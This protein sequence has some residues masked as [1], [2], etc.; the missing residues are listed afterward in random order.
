MATPSL[1]SIAARSLRFFLRS[2]LALVLGIAAATAVI[3]GALAVGDSV[4]GSL[5]NLVVQRLANIECLLQARVFFDPSVVTSLA[6]KQENSTIVPGIIFPS[7][8]VEKRQD[9]N[10]TRASRVQLI[11]LDAQ[12]WAK[13][14]MSEQR[15]TIDAD[16]VVLNQSLADELEVAVGDELSLRINQASGVSGDNPLGKKEGNNISV[17]RQKVVAILPDESV[18]G[19]SF[20]AGQAAPRNVFASLATI[21][22]LLECGS[23]VNAALV[24]RDSATQETM[25]GQAQ[26]DELNLSINP[27]LEDYGLQLTRHRRVFPDSQLDPSS[28]T[29]AEQSPAVVYDYL[30]LSSKELVIDDATSSAVYSAV[31][32]EQSTRLITYL[33]NA[34]AKIEPLQSDLGPD[35]KAILKPPPARPGN[36]PRLLPMGQ[37]RASSQLAQEPASLPLISREVPYSIVVGVDR[38]SPLQLEDYIQVPE[39]SLRRPFC[40]VNS[41]LAEQLDIKP[42]EW[43]QAD[44]FEPETV[45]GREVE[46]KNRFMVAGIVP[47]TEPSR[48]FDR[49]REAAFATTPT[50]FNDPSLT[51]SV[52]GITDQESISNWDLP[53]KLEKTIPP[54]DDLYWKNHRLTPKVFVPYAYA[55]SDEMFGSRFGHTTAIRFSNEKSKNEAAL[56]A[57][58][59][60]ALLTTRLSKGLVFQPIRDRQLAASSGT[61]PFDMLFL[62]LSFFV[63]VAA[64]MLV[65]LLFRLGIQQRSSELGILLAQGFTPA[66]VRRLLLLEFSGVAILGAIV[67]VL[68]GIGYARLMIAGL[69]TWWIGAIAT[70]FLNF[71]VT[72]QSILLGA[73]SGFIASTV[74]IYFGLR[75]LSGM[76]ALAVLQG[77]LSDES[78]SSKSASR[79][80]LAVAGFLAFGAIGLIV[81][82][83]GQAGMARA[84]SFFGS[85]MLL[86]AA[87]LIAIRQWIQV[88]ISAKQ[89]PRK[90]SLLHLAWKAVCKNPL[91]S[92]LSLSLLAVATFLITSMGVFQIS[93]SEK[94]YGGFNL[95]AE[96]SQPIFRDLGSSAVRTEALG[97]DARLLSG[98]TILPM[99]ARLG[100]DASC[101]NLFQ[102]AQPTILGVP[103]RLAEMHD[104]DSKTAEFEW[105]ASANAKNPWLPLARR[106]SGGRNDPIPVILDQNTAAWSLK[107]GA[108]LGAIVRIEL[109]DQVLFFQT[110]GLLSN[111]VLQGKLLIDENNFVDVFPD[112]SGYSFFMVRSGESQEP[113]VVAQTLEKGWSDAGL[114]V[115]YSEDTLARLLGVQN[116][117]ISAFQ[118]LGAL[119]LLLGT[120]GLIAAQVRSVF[121]RRREFALMR[122]V[123]FP[124]HRIARLLT[125]ETAILLIGGLITGI[126]CA[127]LALVPYIIQTGPR[128]S[129]FNPILMLLAVFLAGF[130]AAAIAVRVAAKQ[131][132][133]AALRSQ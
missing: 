17:P 121:E 90:G 5:R 20:L 41:W 109:N 73:L 53:F 3:V 11:A 18:A 124:P 54:V 21:Q 61:T 94:G 102:V 128:L 59:E 69:E 38:D 49:R 46:K 127:S 131:P 42:G 26:C 77:Q 115:T 113:A 118:S 58:I 48:G 122:A 23:Q 33:A 8:T 80:A 95:L 44:Y 91:R 66:R 22:D 107:Q 72:T 100:E 84:G 50:L 106:A 45:D 93:P 19:V 29:E 12:F 78:V 97:E 111:S 62:S 126:L 114:D 67:G 60:E 52:P 16:Q 2:H 37:S 28:A 14:V 4:R 63:I 35:R 104:L 99:R 24:L 9:G 87:A 1:R 105:A 83:L 74:A 56:R 64:L 40:W 13:V 129:V 71:H 89:D 103:L 15:P 25:L 10:V 81:A 68:L 79:V 65:F 86:L 43:F 125:I 36:A 6:P 76:N 55:A 116:T 57:E 101:N 123:G 110:V 117:Y 70:R 32:R 39:D 47:V 34:I 133:L 119:G 75:R 92:S 120:F 108:S 132:V 112:L 88:G 82:G 30:Q 85:G 98:S 96:S 7:S 31:G 27:K 130:I 51:P